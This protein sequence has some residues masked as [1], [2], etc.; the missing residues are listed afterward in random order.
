MVKLI[1]D[2]KVVK[3]FKLIRLIEYIEYGLLLLYH[4][5]HRTKSSDFSVNL[6]PS[7]LQKSVPFG[8]ITEV[9]GPRFQEKAGMQ[10]LHCCSD[11]Q[12]TRA[13]R[14]TACKQL[15]GEWWGEGC[16]LEGTISC[17]SRPD[18]KFSFLRAAHVV[19]LSEVMLCSDEQQT[20]SDCRG[21]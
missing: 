10:V 15:S 4:T 19:G 14:A 3:I 17:F 16:Q 9:F 20:E 5:P 18:L 12:Y 2:L 7:G 6:I 11:E 13:D 1:I 21:S 8:S